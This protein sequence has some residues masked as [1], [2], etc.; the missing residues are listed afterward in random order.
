ME[1]FSQVHDRWHIWR[2]SGL[3]GDEPAYQISLDATGTGRDDLFYLRS[4]QQFYME[5]L[6]DVPRFKNTSDIATTC[7]VLCCEHGWRGDTYSDPLGA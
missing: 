2:G 5:P 6:L 3:W 4:L 7:Y 1:A